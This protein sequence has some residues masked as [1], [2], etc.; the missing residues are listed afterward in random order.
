MP[1]IGGGGGG[2]PAPRPMGGMGGGGGGAG[3]VSCARWRGLWVSCSFYGRVDSCYGVLLPALACRRAMRVVYE[4]GLFL[5]T[6]D[7]VAA[8]PSTLSHAELRHSPK[9]AALHSA[10]PTP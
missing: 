7:G 5:G 10:T 9:T 4:D 2:P 1:G 3:M 6:F 8:K